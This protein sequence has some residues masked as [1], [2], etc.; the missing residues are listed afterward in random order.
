MSNWTR[1]GPRKAGMSVLL[2]ESSCLRK[3][4]FRPPNIRLTSG[5]PSKTV[6][7]LIND[8]AGSHKI[9][10]LRQ[11]WLVDL[12]DSLE[13]RHS[14]EIAEASQLQAEA[15]TKLQ[16]LQATEILKNI[17]AEMQSL[18]AALSRTEEFAGQAQSDC[19]LLKQA[20]RGVTSGETKAR[21]LLAA[22]AHDLRGAWLDARRQLRAHRRA[23]SEQEAHIGCMRQQV[24]LAQTSCTPGAA[25]FYAKVLPT[26]ETAQAAVPD[27]SPP[28]QPT[29]AMPSS[30]IHKACKACHSR[31][32]RCHR[33]W[34][35]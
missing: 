18:K 3:K 31:A 26:E 29:S 10:A 9:E 19:T 30:P 27:G 23:V 1:G 32:S 7:K 15:E 12:L 22:R 11:K 2:D 35:S 20:V 8:Y 13:K 17:Q 24:D 5:G 4:K 25:G 21:R 33:A 14:A 6:L 34:G 16:A 28:Q